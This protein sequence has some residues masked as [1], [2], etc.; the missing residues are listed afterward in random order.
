MSTAT[1]NQIEV[2]VSRRGTPT[3]EMAL[4][5]PNQ[6]DWC[7]HEYLMLDT[8]RLIEFTD[9]VLEFLPV[10]NFSHQDMMLFLYETL[11]AHLKSTRSDNRVYVAPCPIRLRDGQFRE[12]DVFVVSPNRMTDRKTPSDAADLVVEIV[13]E[14]K[15]ARERD[16][17]IKRK[18]Y[19]EAGIPEYWIVDL[20]TTTVSVLTL[21]GK[22]YRTHG[23]F[24][25]G[26][27]ADSVLLDGFAVD[28]QAVFDAG[29]SP[30]K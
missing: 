9:G 5:Y 18:D 8:E 7:E 11:K 28:V 19:A 17:V 2:P 30:T 24:H 29:K 22:E 21:D 25:P 10:P 20:E 16:L 12:P 27:T 4:Q 13:S 1:P 15:E 14:G 23:E 3:W 26:D 6:G